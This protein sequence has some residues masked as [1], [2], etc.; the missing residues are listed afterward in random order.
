[1]ENQ[2]HYSSQSEK[3]PSSFLE[4]VSPKHAFIGGFVTAILAL[5]TIG[6]ILLGNFVLNGADL[7]GLAAKAGTTPTAV[8]PTGAAPAP[9][10]SG[11]VPVVT[12]DD[13]IRGDANA[14]ITLIEYSDFECP[15]CSRF[16]PTVDQVLKDY[17]G[18]VRLVYRHFPLSFHP[19]AESAA[20]A[21]EC[22]GEQGKF[23][24]FHDLLFAD[25]A[26][27]NVTSYKQ[28]ATQLGLNASQFNDCVDTNKYA[29]KVRDQA[30]AG[31]AAGVTGTPGSF[32]VD[33]N[34]TAIPIK[35]ALPFESV[36]QIIDS[37][38]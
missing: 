1:M 6:F 7:T 11:A 20:N 35:G 22:A 17:A 30:S 8:A 13:Y 5:G 28:Y 2:T 37:I 36:K 16:T 26:N 23:Y 21:S 19:S 24:E 4:T 32:V 34:G 3:K 14:K 33:E 25:Q 18:K 12:E 29:Q 9:V 27:L 15:F 10:P 31:A 38:L